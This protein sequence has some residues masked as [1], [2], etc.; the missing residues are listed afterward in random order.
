MES[1]KVEKVLSLSLPEFYMLASLR[2][3]DEVYGFVCDMNSYT[4][5]EMMQILYGL[6]KKQVL[7]V[8][9]DRFVCKESYQ[10][11]LDS[12]Q[13]GTKVLRIQ[14]ENNEIPV[15]IGYM[16]KKLLLTRMSQV[17]SAQL[18]M[19]WKNPAELAQYLKDAGYYD[20]F[21][22]TDLERK[23]SQML[24]EIKVMR[25]PQMQTQKQVVFAYRE[26]QYEMIYTDEDGNIETQ[27]G[28]QG[29]EQFLSRLVSEED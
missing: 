12:V 25:L 28:L 23:D 15:C 19:Q 16:G 11:V 8:K 29:T 26:E 20:G 22:E 14:A 1:R 7:T 21:W 10:K 5:E 6:A 17:H 13:F 24:L 3:L 2:G 18:L 27:R 9:E 4:D